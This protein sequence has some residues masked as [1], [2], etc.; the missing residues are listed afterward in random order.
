MDAK[1]EGIVHGLIAEA[2]GLGAD[3]LQVEYR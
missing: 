3:T 1:D 2:V